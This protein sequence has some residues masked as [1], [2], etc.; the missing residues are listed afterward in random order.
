MVG[1]HVVEDREPDVLDLLGVGDL[2]ARVGV[3]DVEL[4]LGALGVVGVLELGAAD[5]EPQV[6]QGRDL[7]PTWGGGG[8]GG[9]VSDDRH[10]RDRG[11]SGG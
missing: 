10:C 9:G 4:V 5:V 11:S 7:Q 8:G 2:L 3:R 6:L 1:E